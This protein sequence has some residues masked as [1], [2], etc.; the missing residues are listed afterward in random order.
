MTDSR[1]EAMLLD[2]S[3]QD[4][5]ERLLKTG[6]LIAQS[7]S[8]RWGNGRLALHSDYGPPGQEKSE[9]QDYALLWRPPE[10]SDDQRLKWAAAL[11]D[12]VTCSFLPQWGARLAC[13]QALEHL[14][15]GPFVP[16]PLE[17]A[18]QAV[19]AAGEALGRLAEQI[20]ENGE[21]FR[22]DDEFPATWRMRLKWGQLLETTLTLAWLEDETLHVA[23]IGDGGGTARVVREGQV[24]D[25]LLS[26]GAIESDAVHALGPANRRIDALDAWHQ[27]PFGPGTTVALYTDGIGRFVGTS[28]GRLLDRVRDHVAASPDDNAAEAVVRELVNLGA[29]SLED[30]LTLLIARQE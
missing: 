25:R 3:I 24:E 4:C 12:G 16:E 7:G 26:E 23:M 6:R 21:Q 5:R 29:E 13:F 11:A 9:N 10:E 15:A 22:P 14:I 17:R 28:P 2:A 30:N 1:G 8:A 18:V 19:N 27:L 20:A